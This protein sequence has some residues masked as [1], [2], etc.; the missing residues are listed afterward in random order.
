MY[1]NAFKQIDNGSLFREG[2]SVGS[3]ARSLAKIASRVV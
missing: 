2:H 1:E 3:A